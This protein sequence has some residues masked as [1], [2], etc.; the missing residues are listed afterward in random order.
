MSAGIA[1]G[2]AVHATA[3]AYQVF[4]VSLSRVD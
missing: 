2:G 1:V 3:V 4:G